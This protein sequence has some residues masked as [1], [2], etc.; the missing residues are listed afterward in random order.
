MIISNLI[1]SKQFNLIN[2]LY[3]T[4]L[5]KNLINLENLKSSFYPY[6][7]SKLKNGIKISTIEIPN[8]KITNIGI[9]INSGSKNEKKNQSGTAHF[10]EHILFK[11]TKNIP[12]NKFEYIIEQNGS[13]LN[14]YTSREHT[15]YSI[16]CFPKN[17]KQSLN[18]LNEMIQNPLITKKSIDEEKETI[19]AELL[20]FFSQSALENPFDF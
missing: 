7:I 18:I 12:K 6:F 1:K 3:S 4:Q 15:L 2:F 5:S 14:A 20:N 11:G 16:E 13:N 19:K 8:S 10:L 9:Y 17:L